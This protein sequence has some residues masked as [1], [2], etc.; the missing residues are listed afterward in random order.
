M[1]LISLQPQQHQKFSVSLGG[2]SCVI[3]IEQHDEHLYLSL[4]ADNKVIV[5][6]ALCLN[7]VKIIRYKYLGFNGDIYFYD[8]QGDSNPNYKELGSR[9]LLYYDEDL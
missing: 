1:F 5:Q 4:I 6:N 9:F 7:N 3:S 8:T 2:Q